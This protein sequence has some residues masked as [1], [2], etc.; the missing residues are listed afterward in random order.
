MLSFT[1][2][3][4]KTQFGDL[5]TKAQREPVSITCNGRPAVVVVPAEDYAVLEQLKLEALRTRLTRSI[6]QMEAGQVHDGDAV[7]DE[8]MKDL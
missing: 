1:A 2:N 5:M 4:A 6:A 8:L 3:Q 7:F